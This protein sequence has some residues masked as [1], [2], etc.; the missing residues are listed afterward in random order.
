MSD[1]INRWKTV[2]CIWLTIVK[3]I[4]LLNHQTSVLNP[5]LHY[6]WSKT[7]EVFFNSAFPYYNAMY[8]A[9]MF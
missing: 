1:K 9:L 2:Y 6:P 3:P 8:I 4:D 5:F 7:K